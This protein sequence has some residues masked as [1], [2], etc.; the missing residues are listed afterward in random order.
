M[1]QNGSVRCKNVPVLSHRRAGSQG[2][3]LA[4]KVVTSETTLRSGAIKWQRLASRI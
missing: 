2:T 1:D 3:S 4:A